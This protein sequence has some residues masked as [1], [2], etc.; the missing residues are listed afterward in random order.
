MKFATYVM[1]F[2][3]DKWIMRNLENSYPHVDRIYVMHSKLPWGYNPKARETYANTFNLNK[4]LQS[5]YMDK[6]KIVEGDWLS[7]TDERNACLKIAREDNFDYLMVHDAD[8][9]Y[10][11]EDFEKIKKTIEQNPSYHVFD[12]NLYAFWKSF[13]YILIDPQKGKIG[14]TNQTIVDLHKVDHYDYIRDV[15][16]NNRLVVPDVICYHGSYVLTDEQVYRKIKTWSHNNDFDVDKWYREIW[17]PWTLNSKNLH[18]IWPW[19]WDH[20][21]IFE[22]NLPEV[23]QDQKRQLGFIKT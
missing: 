10:F 23:I 6:I 15:H 2:D 7:D 8:E 16:T 5:P 14:G 13:R 17:M 11:H 3:Q 20:C 12:I 18:P 19:C 9:F 4:I 22:G 1:T 21:E